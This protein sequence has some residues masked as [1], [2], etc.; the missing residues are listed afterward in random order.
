MKT[1][2]F[3]SSL[4]VDSK[5][6]TLYE[7]WNFSLRISSVLRI[8]T[9]LL[10]KFL[11]ENFIFCVVTVNEI[12]TRWKCCHKNIRSNL[13]IFLYI[14]K[15]LSRTVWYK[16][17]ILKHDMKRHMKAILYEKSRQPKKGLMKH[18]HLPTSLIQRTFKSPV[19]WKAFHSAKTFRPIMP[20]SDNPTKW[21][22]TVKQFVWVCLTILW[23][24][25]LKG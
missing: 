13:H 5:K 15:Q 6:H 23:D 25:R 11:I 22:N 4:H 1:R 8:W 9:H 7:K 3:Y 18:Q 17:D 19:Y 24:W 2:Y 20:L 12:I 10:K 14:H 16:K 21:S